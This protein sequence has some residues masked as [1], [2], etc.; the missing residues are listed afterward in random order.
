ME[1]RK[2]TGNPQKW[3][4]TI[5]RNETKRNETKRNEIGSDEIKQKDNADIFSNKVKIT[6]TRILE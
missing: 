1:I 6:F 4:Y 3:A 5:L 2:L